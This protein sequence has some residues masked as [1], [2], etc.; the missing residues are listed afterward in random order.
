M[1]Q[2]FLQRKNIKI[3]QINLVDLINKPTIDLN[4]KTQRSHKV[5]TFLK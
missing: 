3:I 1:F 5:V 2:G 4:Q